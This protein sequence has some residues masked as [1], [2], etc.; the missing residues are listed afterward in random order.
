MEIN[1]TFSFSHQN[2][3]LSEK[4]FSDKVKELLKQRYENE[5]PS[6][7]RMRFLF[8]FAAALEVVETKLV[9]KVDVLKN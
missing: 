5:K 2:E 6:A 4:M 3:I 9:G 7:S 1:S 8:D